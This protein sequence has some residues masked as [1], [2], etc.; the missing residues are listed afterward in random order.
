M[1]GHNKW[2][3]IKRKK[4][5]TDKKR[6]QIFSK[7]LR[8]ISVAA[9]KDPNPLYN[10]QLKAAIEK[11][12]EANIPQENIER[13]IKKSSEVKNVEDI[14]MEAYGPEGVALLIEAQT[15]NRNRTTAEVKK[16]L[17]NHGA[18]WADPGSVMWAFE[19]TNEGFL[20]KFLQEISQSAE[21]KIL[22]LM[23]ELDDHDDVVEIH[24]N[25][26]LKQ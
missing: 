5:I 10:P 16:I 2:T 11:A 18:K 25:A 14:I 23:E 15:D 12:R 9:K 22:K 20:P 24:T 1:A 8:A 21:E 19:K 7:L 13:A 6:G 4:E 3:Q 17:S 26:N